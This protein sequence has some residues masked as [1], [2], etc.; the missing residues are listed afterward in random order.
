MARDHIVERVGRE[1]AARIRIRSIILRRAIIATNVVSDDCCSSKPAGI[2]P[3][4]DEY[5]LHGVFGIV[6]IAK[7]LSGERPDEA[8]VCLQAV[9]NSA[10]RPSAIRCKIA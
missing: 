2:F 4:V 10:R 9:L 8:A 7:H 5:L 1:P 6:G 3:N